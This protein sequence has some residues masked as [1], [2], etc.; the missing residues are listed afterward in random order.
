[1][2]DCVM[3]LF[4]S[5]GYFANPAE[6]VTVLHNVATALTPGGT[7]VV[8]YLNVSHAERTLVAEERVEKGRFTRRR[9]RC[10]GS[11]TGKSSRA[12][13]CAT[14]CDAPAARTFTDGGHSLS[15]PPLSSSPCV[16]AGSRSH[17]RHLLTRVSWRSS[18]AGPKKAKAWT[19]RAGPD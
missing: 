17:D 5:L 11:K 7:L 19:H 10:S 14:T 2:F 16:R 13:L 3:S 18:V 8:D 1:M 9:C 15:G 6:N 4:T 12:G